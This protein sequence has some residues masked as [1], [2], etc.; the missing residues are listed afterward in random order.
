MSK[1][2]KV[3]E[4]VKAAPRPLVKPGAAK[5]RTLQFSDR[6]NGLSQHWGNSVYLDLE[7]SGAFVFR[8]RRGLKAALR[9]ALA[10]RSASYRSAVAA[11]FAA[12]RHACQS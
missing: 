12:R 5:Q 11:G 9:S 2:A 7:V 6:K 10:S 1:A 8:R 4:G 3:R